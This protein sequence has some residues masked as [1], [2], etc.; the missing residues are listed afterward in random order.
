MPTPA[1]PV[2]AQRLGAALHAERAEV[3]EREVAGHQIG[4]GLRDEARVRLG[5]R[6]DPLREAHGVPLRGVVH[7]QVVADLADHH[8]ARVEPDARREV[9]AVLAAHRAP[10]LAQA[11]E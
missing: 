4:R 8:L 6:F 3:L 2:H 11:L 1:R 10:V 5:Q 7:A 9:E